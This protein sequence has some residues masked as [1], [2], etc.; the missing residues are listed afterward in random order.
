MCDSECLAPGIM[1]LNVVS[2]RLCPDKHE[3]LSLHGVGSIAVQEGSFNIARMDACRRTAAS[4][5]MKKTF[6]VT[7]TA[8]NLAASFEYELK[9]KGCDGVA[10]PPVTVSF[11][12][13]T[14]CS[15][16]DVVT[17]ELTAFNAAG[18]TRFPV[19]LDFNPA[20]IQFEASQNDG[21]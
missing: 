17:Q 12:P 3:T 18:T 4:A 1:P 7:P 21:W 13:D 19:Q 15:T 9:V 14:S 11:C 10:T 8:P 5:H 16:S 20:S 6:C 2:R